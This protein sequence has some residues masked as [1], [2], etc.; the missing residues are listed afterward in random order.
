MGAADLY[1]FDYYTL[2]WS[3][4]MCSKPFN[5]FSNYNS[6][7]EHQS[8]KYLAAISGP[9]CKSQHFREAR[10]FCRI[11]SENRTTTSITV[12]KTPGESQRPPLGE[13]YSGRQFEKI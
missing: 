7:D 8:Q 6:S 10:M 1:E 4:V 5:L 3:K 11:G 12:S 9:D 2:L 13:E